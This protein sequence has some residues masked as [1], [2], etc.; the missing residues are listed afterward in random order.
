[1]KHSYKI[2][3][4]LFLIAVLQSC[5]REKYATSN[6]SGLYE[7]TDIK[8]ETWELTVKTD[9]KSYTSSAK[10]YLSPPSKP[11]FNNGKCLLDTGGTVPFFLEPLQLN[12]SNPTSGNNPFVFEWN[13]GPG[14]KVRLS[15]IAPNPSI[16]GD[17][18]TS[19]NVKRNALGAVVAWTFVKNLS[20][21]YEFHT[22]KVKR[23]NSKL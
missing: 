11:G 3:G 14:D 8:V 15:F 18:S 13:L 22:Y 19:V 20:N 9:E 4:L 16:P 10:F 23:R 7:I 6:F 21:G 2:I 1:M 17:L 5:Y 12:F